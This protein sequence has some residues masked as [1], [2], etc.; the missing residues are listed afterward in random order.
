MVGWR[1]K[2]L[3]KLLSKSGYDGF[4][5][6]CRFSVRNQYE[7]SVWMRHRTRPFDWALSWSWWGWSRSLSWW[8]WWG[9]SRVIESDGRSAFFVGS[10][11]VEWVNPFLERG[12]AGWSGVCYSMGGSRWR[13]LEFPDTRGISCL[14]M[15]IVLWLLLWLE[16]ET[17][18]SSLLCF[19]SCIL[20][21]TANTIAWDPYLSTG[22]P[23]LRDDC[24][25]NSSGG[26]IVI[27][28][29]DDGNVSIS[30]FSSC[31]S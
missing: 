1:C 2:L 27:L 20:T 18:R 26:T 14:R 6:Y 15:I 30:C 11:D 9:K 4:D 24:L 16:M 8:S 13:R 28:L 12:T 29:F 19:N 25:G 5:C 23:Q 31:L 3:I 7:L 10:K 17:P 21:L 22:L